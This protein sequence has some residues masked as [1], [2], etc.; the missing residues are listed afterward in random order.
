[1]KKILI[2]F[3]A[4]L[5][6][7]TTGC[8]KEKANIIFNAEPITAET[9]MHPSRE[10]EAGQRIYYLFFTPEKIESKYIRVQVFKVNDKINRGGYSIYWTNDYRVMKQNLYYYYN[11][12]TIHQGGRYVMQVFDIENL[13]RPLAYNEFWI[14][15]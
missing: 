13:A 3:T 2:C 7:F 1:M 11:H 6:M 10:F 15:N 12:F 9:V 4:L 5:L 8:D 14:R